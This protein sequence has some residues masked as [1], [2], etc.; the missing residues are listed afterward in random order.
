M[1]FRLEQEVLRLQREAHT[2]ERV[3][4][5]GVWGGLV[6]DK[7]PQRSWYGKQTC[8]GCWVGLGKVEAPDGE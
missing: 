8:R 4:S 5:P 1:R 2:R 3:V 6:L 7:V